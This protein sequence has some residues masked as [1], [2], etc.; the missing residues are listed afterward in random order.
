MYSQ[1]FPNCTT[2]P[3]ERMEHHSFCYKSSWWIIT[4]LLQQN[5][6]CAISGFQTNKNNNQ[7]YDHLRPVSSNTIDRIKA[8]ATSDNLSLDHGR[9][10]NSIRNNQS[11]NAVLIFNDFVEFLKQQ[12]TS[13]IDEI[14]QQIEHSSG[15]KFS[16][17]GW[18]I[19]EDECNDEVISTTTAT[20]SVDVQSGGITRVI[21]GGDVIEKGACSLTLIQ[22]GILTS[23]RASTIRS[24][25]TESES[26][27]AAGDSYSAAALSIVFHTRSPLIPTFRSDVRIFMVHRKA[28]RSL[29]EDEK[30]DS[31]SNS[32]S[33]DQHEDSPVIAWFG[34]GADLTP[35]YLD[36]EDISSFHKQYQTLCHQHELPNGYTYHDMKIA[37][38]NY[39]YLPSRQEHRGTGGIFFDDMMATDST[40]NFVKGVVTTWMPSW[41]SN[42]VQKY[43][44]KSYTQQQKD[45]Q[46]IRRGRYLEFNLLYDVSKFDVCEPS[47]INRKRFI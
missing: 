44:T 14:E 6:F 42:I 36:K 22:N 26:A 3:K 47:C 15:C 28:E 4:I 21:Q 29:S 30:I 25:Q 41:L 9:A 43:A 16:R 45:W 33:N 35:Y 38:D 8:Y 7:N 5:L 39:F 31:D 17:D 12:Q 20:R 10:C 37:C 32:N 24:R 40:L 2:Q 13:I 23:E 46:L 1:P 18:G 27:V 19:F 11:E 34:G